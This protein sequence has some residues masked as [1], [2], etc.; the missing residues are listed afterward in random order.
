MQKNRKKKVSFD[1]AVK[2]FMRNYEICT[3]K[4]IRKL[5]ARL[6]RIENNIKKLKPLIRGK[7]AGNKKK[8]PDN[9]LS[10]TASDVV[11]EIVNNS[12]NGIKFADIKNETGFE[13]K[14]LRNIIFR[15][16]KMDRIR[17]KERGI[18]MPL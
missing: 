3:K 15:L 4:D 6:D 18:Y 11:I 8:D 1:T 5:I 17:T 2:V 14:K 13:E 9:S 10:M 16:T 12:A 7:M